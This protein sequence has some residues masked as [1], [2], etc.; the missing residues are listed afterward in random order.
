LIAGQVAVVLWA[1]VF[2]FVRGKS[3][4]KSKR[5]VWTGVEGRV[6]LE[7]DVGLDL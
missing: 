1:R 7:L 4:S 5:G 2:E 6:L 3:E